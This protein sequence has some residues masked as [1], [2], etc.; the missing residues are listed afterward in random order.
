MRTMNLEEAAAWLFTTPETVSE[1]IRR[2]GLPAAKIGRAWVLVDV[3][4]IDWLRQQYEKTGGKCGSTS[5][6]KMALGGSTSASTARE[7]DNLL[8]P[9]TVGRRKNLPPRLRAITGGKKSS[10][11][12]RP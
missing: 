6:K 5:D 12:G 8:A 2:H 7:L 9:R 4:V 10:A 3:D 11:S 1:C